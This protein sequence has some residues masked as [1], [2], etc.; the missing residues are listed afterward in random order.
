MKIISNKKY[1]ELLQIKGYYDGDNAD[2]EYFK[3]IAAQLVSNKQQFSVGCI[4]DGETESAAQ[5]A[6]I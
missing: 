4:D 6:E 2:N 5:G 3:Q 1:K